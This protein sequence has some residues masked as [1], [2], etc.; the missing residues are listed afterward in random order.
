MLLAASNS[1]PGLLHLDGFDSV[2]SYK[3][4]KDQQKL[5]FLLGNNVQV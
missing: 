1:P 2:Q 5:V 4:K 3:S